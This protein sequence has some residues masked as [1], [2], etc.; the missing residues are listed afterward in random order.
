MTMTATT[1][2]TTTTTMTMMIIKRTMKMSLY[3][4]YGDGTGD[5]IISLSGGS[6]H[7]LSRFVDIMVEKFVS[8]RAGD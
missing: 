1:E 3:V 8:T 2:V 6:I 7:I 4:W 5:F